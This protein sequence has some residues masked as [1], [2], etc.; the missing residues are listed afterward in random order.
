M[1]DSTCWVGFGSFSVRGA[2]LYLAAATPDFDQG[3]ILSITPGML[4]G[5][6]WVSKIA[7]RSGM[8]KT[9]AS[10]TVLPFC[11]IP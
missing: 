2:L 5:P 1:G 3:Y 8:C 4:K 10:T 7:P 9:S 6:Y 11:S